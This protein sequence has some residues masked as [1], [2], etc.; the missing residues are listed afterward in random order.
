MRKNKT[1]QAV[2]GG[3]ILIA[4]G[5]AMLW[6][7]EGNNVKNIKTVAEAREV[8]IDVVNSPIDSSNDGKLINVNGEV[9]I[10]EGNPYDE[11]F[12][13]ELQ[14]TRLIR[15]VEVFQWQE[16]EEKDSNDNVTYKY[17]QI[18]D[19][20]VRDSRTFKNQVGYENP[21]E[22]DFESAEFF[23]E[24]VRIGDFKV[25]EEQLKRFSATEIFNN[26]D[27]I[28]I[29][30]G[31][32]VDNDYITTVS[33]QEEIGD[34]RISFLYNDSETATML[35][36]QDGDS[37][38]NYRTESGAKINVLRTET[39]NSTEMLDLME[40]QNNVMKWVFRLVGYVLT[41]MGV[42]FLFAP[43]TLIAKFIPIVR[44]L[45]GA[46]I[47]LV[48]LL[49]GTALSTLVIAIAWLFFRPLLGIGLIAISL[50]LV[51]LFVKYAKSKQSAVREDLI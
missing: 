13:L 44:G 33:G 30:E 24:D 21:T 9:Q 14:T 29:P 49:L 28:T 45:V 46:A 7:N 10:M 50:V 4:I 32:A 43:I 31:Y 35:G 11:Q 36:K 25:S 17:D 34:I 15:K 6:I 5:V 18:W 40:S 8:V 48:S 42:F 19:E 3:F 41:T 26:F 47:M 2:L 22:V 1:V 20:G 23:A 51:S 37:V 38:V 16:I 39:Y 12:D 27:E